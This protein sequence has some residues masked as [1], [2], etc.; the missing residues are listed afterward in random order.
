MAKTPAKA[1]PT[2]PDLPRANSHEDKSRG[3]G[4]SVFNKVAPS[5]DPQGGKYQPLRKG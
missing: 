3:K 4:V 1:L 2:P 5:A